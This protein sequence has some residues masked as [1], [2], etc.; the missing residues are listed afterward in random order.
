MS[1]FKRYICSSVAIGVFSL[2]NVA[3]ARNCNFTLGA[4]TDPNG[5]SRNISRLNDEEISLLSAKGYHLTS[6]FEADLVFNVRSESAVG[7]W[8]VPGSIAS[9]FMD[10]VFTGTAVTTGTGAFSAYPYIDVIS[11]IKKLDKCSES[12]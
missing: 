9:V 8:F 5:T 10:D 1:A 11:A 7:L 6:E 3:M 12:N 4:A 2:G